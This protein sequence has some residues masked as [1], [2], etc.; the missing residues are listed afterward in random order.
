MFIGPVEGYANVLTTEGLA[1]ICN[2]TWE[3][4]FHLPHRLYY[5]VYPEYRSRRF[6]PQYIPVNCIKNIIDDI[7]PIQNLICPLAYQMVEAGK[8]L[9]VL[10]QLLP[11]TADSLKPAIPKSSSMAV[12]K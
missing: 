3:K 1:V 7:Y 12:L 2:Y 10:D 11:E 6:D 8:K 9:Y 5:A 4:I